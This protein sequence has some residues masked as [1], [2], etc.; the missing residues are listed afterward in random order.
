LLVAQVQRFDASGQQ[1]ATITCGTC[2]SQTYC[3]GAN[4]T[5]CT[6]SG[7]TNNAMRRAMQM[8]L[9]RNI[10]NDSLLYL[11]IP[12]FAEFY[13]T[14]Q[15]SEFALFVRLYERLS[16]SLDSTGNL[17]VDS[18]YREYIESLRNQLLQLAADNL[19]A[20][21]ERDVAN[22]Y[23]Q[24]FTGD[25]DTLVSIADLNRLYE[26]ANNCPIVSGYS[27]YDAQALLRILNPEVEYD[28]VTNCEDP[29][30]RTEDEHT[31]EYDNIFVIEPTLY[32]NPVYDVLYISGLIGKE[33]IIIYNSQGQIV[34]EIIANGDSLSI[35][36]NDLV[37][38]V[39]TIS[40]LNLENA[41]VKKFVVI[42]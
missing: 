26:I 16:H 38:G 30:L 23:L 28:W 42:R 24:Y 31:N 1:P 18:T 37:N 12:Q 41:I 33:K 10:V 19:P 35:S 29:S 7:Q 15:Q 40:I 4:G 39:Y 3:N 14:H 34:K 11:Q 27:V 17:S 21:Y 13:N 2:I 20:I 32:P 6:T 5:Y 25:D 36:T 9:Y 8:Y 22:I